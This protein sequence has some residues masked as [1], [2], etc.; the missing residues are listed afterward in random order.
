MAKSHS[1][2]KF[3]TSASAFVLGIAGLA[4]LL[5]CSRSS[6]DS[7]QEIIAGA[8]RGDSI[9]KSGM[10]SY[11]W[12][13]LGYGPGE[14]K[15][16]VNYKYRVH[17]AFDGLKIDRNVVNIGNTPHFPGAQRYAFDGKKAY[18]LTQGQNRDVPLEWSGDISYKPENIYPIDYNTDPRFIGMTMN[19]IPVGA[20]LR[21]LSR[22]VFLENREENKRLTGKESSG[23]TV[24]NLRVLGSEIVDGVSCIK[25]SYEIVKGNIAEKETIW[26]APIGCTGL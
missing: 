17:F 5:S 10:G 7:L 19:G 4:A 9:I 12:E 15:P 6:P 26:I 23:Y 16:S 8:E 13:Q 14:S 2:L 22:G 11:T 24:K 18:F 20:F 25:I 3:F 1:L 21:A